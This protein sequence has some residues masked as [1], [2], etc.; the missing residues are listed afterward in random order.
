MLVRYED[1]VQPSFDLAQISEHCGLG[2]VKDVRGTVIRGMQRPPAS[3]TAFEVAQIDHV[4]GE[5]ARRCCYEP[6]DA[7]EETA[8]PTASI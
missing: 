7:V 2:S 4:C 8:Q 5:L 6:S 3:L 1:L